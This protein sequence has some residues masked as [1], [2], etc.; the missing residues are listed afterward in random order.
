MLLSS[1]LKRYFLTIFTSFSGLFPVGLSISNNFQENHAA[2]SMKP[3]VYG[4][5][6]PVRKQCE[7]QQT[8][9]QAETKNTSEK[10]G[11]DF[12]EFIEKSRAKNVKTLS[13]IDAKRKAKGMPTPTTS[14]T[15][16]SFRTIYGSRSRDTLSISQTNPN[17]ADTVTITTLGTSRAQLMQTPSPTASPRVIDTTSDIPPLPKPLLWIL[18]AFLLLGLLATVKVYFIVFPSR[19]WLKKISY[20]VW[21]L[22]RNAIPEDEHGSVHSE[23]SGKNFNIEENLRRDTNPEEVDERLNSLYDI[24]L[25]AYFTASPPQTP[26][27][28]FSTARGPAPH[29]TVSSSVYSTPASTPMTAT[30]PANY[31]TNLRH[32][33]PPSL[34]VEPPSPTSILPNA[35]KDV[36]SQTPLATPTRRSFLSLA[37]SAMDGSVS[38]PKN[39]GKY[40]TSKQSMSCGWVS[41]A[42]DSVAEGLVR[43]TR[44][45]GGERGLLLPLREDKDFDAGF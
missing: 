18:V 14:T 33:Q 42:V 20:R 43:Y 30:F 15:N 28:S 38:A 40:G 39:G 31:S 6:P 1:I 7:Q 37:P 2:A 34:H 17:P 24:Q 32:R 22:R 29:A 4:I 27:S 12:K 10:K 5:V 21:G 3:V 23:L 26:M 44:D 25:P 9:A 19:S 41:G 13:Q 45:D 8:K 16:M 11:Q 35:S 36:E